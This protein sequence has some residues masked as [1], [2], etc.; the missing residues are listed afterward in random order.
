MVGI[1]VEELQERFGEFLV[2]DL[3]FM[4]RKLMDP[5]W[6]TLAMLEHVETQMHGA[7]RRDLRGSTPPVLHVER[8]SPNT[9]RVQY[10]SKRR[11]GALAVGI[12]R[13]LAHH[14]GEHDQLRIAPT[15][16]EDGDHVDHVD[17]VEILVERVARTV[18]SAA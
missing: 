14:F 17:H 11:M 9:V 12:V 8:F 13:G 2:P 4:Y 1:P 5:S 18:P 10:V 7:V 15:T 3:P 6:D 16:R